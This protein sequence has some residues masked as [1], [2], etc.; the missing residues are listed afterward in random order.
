MSA[1]I[2]TA[3]EDKMITKSDLYERLIDNLS[4]LRAVLNMTQLAMSSKHSMP[5]PGSLETFLVLF[6]KGLI[7]PMPVRTD[8]EV[9]WLL[10]QSMEDLRGTLIELTRALPSAEAYWDDLARHQNS[11]VHLPEH[12]RQQ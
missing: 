10:S 1:S 7:L 12:G 6:D 3:G 5:A 11:A 9:T 4:G 2:Q 8:A